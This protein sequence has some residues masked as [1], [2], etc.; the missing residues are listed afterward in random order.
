MPKVI[1]NN[2]FS[3]FVAIRV[4]P[5]A[6]VIVSVKFA[7]RIMSNNNFTSN[8]LT[9][10]ISRISPEQKIIIV[11]YNKLRKNTKVLDTLSNDSILL[12]SPEV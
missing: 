7:M 12:C 1:N 11:V 6:P 4:N 10:H 8:V 3:L 5:Q 9:F 2:F